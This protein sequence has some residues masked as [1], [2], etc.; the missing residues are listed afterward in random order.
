MCNAERWS[1]RPPTA[2]VVV[3]MPHRARPTLVTLQR[4]DKEITV[5]LVAPPPG[6]PSTMTVPTT[7]ERDSTDLANVKLRN[8]ETSSGA[9]AGGRGGVDDLINLPHLHEP[10]I[11]D[12]LSTRYARDVIYTYTGPILLAVNPF[13]RLPLYTKQR[14]EEYYTRGL[15]R[16]QGAG[17]SALE[18]LPPHVYAV[19]D[20]AYRSMMDEKARRAVANRN[21][22]VLI[23][24]ESGAGKTETTKFAMQYLATVG[25]P[26]GGP[27]AFD[28]AWGPLGSLTA[29]SGASR[30]KSLGTVAAADASAASTAATGGV[31]SV[32]QRVLESNPILEAFGN[33]KTLR[34]ENSSRFGKFI[35][36]QVGIC[37]RAPSPINDDCNGVKYNSA[38]Y[39]T[40][41]R[42]STH[43]ACSLE[44]Q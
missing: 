24:G 13:Q 27:D 40:V 19:S 1:A 36:L 21:Q 9:G 2:S 39:L 41:P 20:A 44:R 22:S 26:R 33:A 29:S 38:L 16:G 34:N 15:L 37:N 42:S 5:E 25:R 31:A 30:P 10:A 12:V 4:S 28:P 32:E 14:L 7:L 11:L 17:V 43:A 8:S 23:S 3:V 18:P 6:G 35:T